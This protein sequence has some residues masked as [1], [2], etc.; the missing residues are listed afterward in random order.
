MLLMSLL[1]PNPT[2][3]DTVSWSAEP[4]P[5]SIDMVL[6]PD[7]IDVRDLAVTDDGVTVYAV[8][9]DSIPENV[10]YKSTD[11]GVSWTTLSISIVADL[12]A[13][14]PDDE[15]ASDDLAAAPA[16][17]D[18]Y[19]VEDEDGNRVRFRQGAFHRQ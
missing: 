10:V 5:S 3:A 16:D 18:I 6:G 1:I 13:V 8:S 2:S 7:V 17:A 14:A 9:G 15:L 19:L 11:A 12:V 4:V